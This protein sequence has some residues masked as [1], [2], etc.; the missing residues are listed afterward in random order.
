MYKFLAV[1]LLLCSVQ[2]V[3]A[4]KI[5]ETDVPLIVKQNF[6][7]KYPDVKVIKWEKEHDDVEVSFYLNKFQSS[8]LYDLAGN[9]KEFEQEMSIN[10]M[11]KNV[12]TYSV[13][14]F[15]GFQPALRM[16]PLRPSMKLKWT[17]A[18]STSSCYLICKAIS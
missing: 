10:E 14:N 17:K 1:L 3:N 8:A 7:K 4:Q 15:H 16:L 6:A 18:R 5:N 11:P 12:L 9:F 2:F 13:N